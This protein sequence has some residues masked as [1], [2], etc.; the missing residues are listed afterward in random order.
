MRHPS[1]IVAIVTLLASWGTLYAA[2]VSA[3]PAANA[4]EVTVRDSVGSVVRNADVCLYD[5]ISGIQHYGLTDASGQAR[6]E[7]IPRDQVARRSLV[8]SKNGYRGTGELLIINTPPNQTTE[9]SKVIQV[10]SYTA[11]PVC[12]Q[13]PQVVTFRV[14][15]KVPV[16]TEES[17][18]LAF[19]TSASYDQE[20]EYCA[21]LVRD[22]C[23]IL[24]TKWKKLAV[25]ED[26]GHRP[27]YEQPFPLKRLGQQT[28]YLGVR[29]SSLR[30]PG[31]IVS[32]IIERRPDDISVGP[33]EINAGDAETESREV[34]LS[35]SS[36]PVAAGSRLQYCAY[37]S[38]Q[39]CSDWQIPRVTQSGRYE[40]TYNLQEV[41]PEQ[42]ESGALRSV[43]LV[44]RYGDYPDVAS[45]AVSDNIRIRC[46][47]ETYTFSADE[48]HEAA[49]QRG[50]TSSFAG[51][52]CFPVEVDQQNETLSIAAPSGRFL[53]WTAPN[54]CTYDL[55]NGGGLAPGWS[56]LS[57]EFDDTGL[58]DN[59]FCAYTDQASPSAGD[60]SLR[61][62][63][64]IT[65]ENP[66]QPPL[67]GTDP[68]G[69][70]RRVYR[71]FQL[72][73]PSGLSIE[74]VFT[75]SD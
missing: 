38:G 36:E 61:A 1:G 13:L 7:G 49:S 56:F 75:G 31:A 69:I 73:G 14:N 51:N 20:L 29:W 11:G 72:R 45:N 3:Q 42:C 74:N 9:L 17:V 30:R 21:S 53:I 67:F 37:E 34:S 12:S 55:F 70:C 24:S 43:S 39:S 4:I 15:N 23:S 18:S 22:D 52:N 57:S 60:P 16:T 2:R 19:S 65:W 26:P 44:M 71:L 5:G 58:P 33:L 50:L 47:F 41:P 54:T 8:I 64:S 63:V 35:W 59:N 10:G 62:R 40:A 28:I 6:I 48:I 66:I 68:P 25:A 32:D 27:R 46:R